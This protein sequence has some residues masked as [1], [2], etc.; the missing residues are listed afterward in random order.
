MRIVDWPGD[1]ELGCSALC[2]V[3]SAILVAMEV[4][5]PYVNIRMLMKSVIRPANLHAIAFRNCRQPSS[6]TYRAL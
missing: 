5:L 3:V 2:D 1:V 4:A 6:L